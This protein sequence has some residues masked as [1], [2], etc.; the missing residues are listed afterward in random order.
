VMEALQGSEGR[1]AQSL[2]TLVHDDE[3]DSTTVGDLIGR[4]DRGYELAEARA[5]IEPLLSLLDDR[6]RQVLRL[7]FE[8]DLRQSEIADRIGCSQMHASR[9]IRCSLD[10]LYVHGTGPR[11][12][13]TR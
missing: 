1:W 12:P 4:N 13:S 5:T 6:A 9:I 8:E 11:T 3:D 10:K 2:D 7:R